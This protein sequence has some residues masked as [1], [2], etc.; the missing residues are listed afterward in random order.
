MTYSNR[1]GEDAVHG[2]PKIPYSVYLTPDFINKIK[3][4]TGT[5]GSNLEAQQARIER[6]QGKVD[7]LVEHIRIQDNHI[8]KLEG[9][10]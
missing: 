1:G 10:R 5:F 4:K 9:A 6:L 3:A 7:K 2:S 8:K